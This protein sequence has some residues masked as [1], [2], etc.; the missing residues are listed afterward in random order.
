MNMV[1]EN[2]V[3]DPGMIKGLVRIFYLFIA[4]LVGGSQFALAC[5]YRGAAGPAAQVSAST[6]PPLPNA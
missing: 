1:E 5:Y 6:L 4:V 3:I 2:N